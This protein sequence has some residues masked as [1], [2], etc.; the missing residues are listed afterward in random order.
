M[1]PVNNAIVP[2]QGVRS[3][4]KAMD[5]AIRLLL[6][7]GF[8]ET[9]AFIFYTSVLMPYYRTL[10]FGPEVAGILNSVLQ[11]SSAVTLLIS[12]FAADRLGRKRLYIGGQLMRC[13]VAGSLLFTKSYWG[14]VAIHVVRGLGSMQSPAQN[15]IVAE[16]SDR[17]TLAT[18]FAFVDTLAQ[19]AAVCAPILAGAV[20]DKYGVKVPFTIGLTL[21]TVAVILGLGIKETKSGATSAEPAKPSPS[22]AKTAD[23]NPSGQTKSFLSQISDMFTHNSPVALYLLLAANLVSGL[24]NG[25]VGIILPFTIM[26]RFSDTYTAVSAV[27]TAAALGTMLVLVLGGRL[28]DLYGRRRVIMTSLIL[29]PTI[30]LVFGATSIWQMYAVIMVVTLIGNLSSPAI[31]ALHLEVV[32]QGDRASFSGLSSGLSSVGYALG[33]VLA[34]FCYKWSPNGAWIVDIIL[35]TLSGVLFVMAA[36]RHERSPGAEQEAVATS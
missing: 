21:A 11:V 4:F 20:A 27:Q 7:I 24:A 2:K 19:F 12:G 32:R 13:I 17:S 22:T 35:F 36:S 16:Y 1:S 5:P 14:F 23:R 3:I 18:S 9:T 6:V 34:G 26:D 8:L 29:P 33:S 15:A 28:A 31:R 30:A 10:G 25:T